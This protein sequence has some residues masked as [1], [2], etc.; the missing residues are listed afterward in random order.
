MV[1]LDVHEEMI[2]LADTRM[3][4]T[5]VCRLHS[6][7]DAKAEEAFEHPLVVRDQFGTEGQCEGGDQQIHGTDRV[8]LRGGRHLVPFAHLLTRPRTVNEE[9]RESCVRRPGLRRRLRTIHPIGLRNIHQAAVPFQGLAG[10]PIQ[11]DGGP[12]L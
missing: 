9:R 11:A 10:L 3:Q 1:Q 4:I 2:R 8:A 5:E 7:L 6:V 12:S